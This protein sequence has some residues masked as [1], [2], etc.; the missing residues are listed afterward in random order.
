M[1]LTPIEVDQQQFQR[2]F[3]GCDPDEVHRFLDLVSRELE[4]LIR[5][6]AGLKEDLKRRDAQI[7]E[8]RAHEA[9]LREALV[10][11]GRMSDEMRASARKEAE[12][13]V[14]EAE[15]RAGRIEADAR[16]RNALLA[17]EI[18]ELKR[19]RARL[20]GEVRAILGSHAR[21]LDA[22]EALDG[23]EA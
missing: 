20:L 12:V 14:A 8:F 10:S 3:R 23:D 13:V 22:H 4:E 5:E 17:A 6:N 15:V 11:A 16:E 18:H 7:V 2:V 21:L 1:K 19:Q 9:Q